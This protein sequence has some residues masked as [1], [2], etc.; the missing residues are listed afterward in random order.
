MKKEKAKYITVLDSEAGRVFQYK[1]KDLDVDNESCEDFITKKSHRLS[2]CQWMVHEEPRVIDK[3][4]HL[5][6]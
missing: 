5:F 2:K 4:Y 3:N 6:W 1:V